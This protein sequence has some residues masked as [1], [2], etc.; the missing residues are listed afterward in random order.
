[1]IHIMRIFLPVNVQTVAVQIIDP[2]V[3]TVARTVRIIRHHIEVEG[4]III[5]QE[6][7]QDRRIEVDVESIVVK[8]L[9]ILLGIEIHRHGGDVAVPVLLITAVAVEV[10]GVIQVIE[11][12]E[13]HHPGT[14]LHP[15]TELLRLTIGAP[16]PSLNVLILAMIKV[17]MLPI[18]TITI[19]IVM[20]IIAVLQVMSTIA[21]Q[22]QEKIILPKDLKPI[23]VRLTAKKILVEIVN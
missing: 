7:D 20:P 21:M 3:I 8:D 23:K 9:I 6:I 16:L 15:V 13:V 4:F 19:V 2:S 12:V 14:E 11:A 10:A 22:S 18:L 1:M 17:A 5:H